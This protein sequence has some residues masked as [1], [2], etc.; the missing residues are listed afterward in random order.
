M[1]SAPTNLAENW[2]RFVAWIA[3]N[4]LELA[5]AAGGALL[6]TAVLLGLRGI[7]RHLLG[8]GAASGWRRVAEGVVKRTRGFFLAAMAVRIATVPLDLPDRLETLVHLLFVIAAA[9]QGAIW[10]RALILGWIDERVSTREEHRTLGTAMTLIRVFVTVALFL[11]ALIVIL[12]NVGVSVTGL[13]AGLGIGGIAIGLA[14]QGIFK[15]L[16]AA[17][18]IIFDRPFQKGDT[19][20]FGSGPAAFTGTVETIGLRTTRLRSLDGEMVAIGNDKLLQDRIHNHAVQMRRR[21]VLTYNLVPNAD[22]ELIAR[23]VT[24]AEE[25]VRAQD[26]V[27][28]DRVSLVKLSLASADIEIVFFMETADF[29]AFAATR[30]RVL[31]EIQRRAKALE[32]C[33]APPLTAA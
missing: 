15:D 17:L 12:D 24:E 10:V 21:A 27:T 2:N 25:V 6:I 28:L 13:I 9:L 23:L 3:E 4:S 29:A 31:L 14:A 8:G 18:S 20:T 7:V 33:P 5:M 11:I 1:L 19:I 30:Q 16:F 22:P 32:I 26:Q